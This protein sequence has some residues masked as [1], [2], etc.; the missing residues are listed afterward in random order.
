[1]LDQSAPERQRASN[2][3]ERLIKED[4]RET[5]ATYLRK[6]SGTLEQK[7]GLDK[8][9]L[10]NDIREQIWKGLLTHR[11]EGG[12]NLKTYLNTLIKNRFGVLFKRSK[13]KKNNMV[14]YY[15]DVYSSVDVQEEHM[16]T[17]ETGETVF[18]RRQIVS[19]YLAQ[20]SEVDRGVY[21]ELILGKRLE[22]MVKSLSLPR[23][24]VIASI[25]RIADLANKR[26]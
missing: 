16:V 4:L 8:G 22:E 23:P 17:E 19:Q 26:K 10:L 18:M 5:V 2:E 6:Y 7:L 14:S 24:L 11:P 3:I 9:D 15:A 25:N 1:M 13:I 20:L 12:A 21:Q